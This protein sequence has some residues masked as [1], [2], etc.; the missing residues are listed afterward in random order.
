MSADNINAGRTEVHENIDH[1]VDENYLGGEIIS[2]NKQRFNFRG[3]Q[4]K[5]NVS[6]SQRDTFLVDILAS[7]L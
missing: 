3:K 5:S 6:L 1:G 4:S 2:N 7:L